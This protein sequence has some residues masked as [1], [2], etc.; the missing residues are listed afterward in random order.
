[1]AVSEAYGI[2]GMKYWFAA[3]TS[4]TGISPDMAFDA[5]TLGQLLFLRRLRSPR[6]RQGLHQNLA[7]AWAEP[8]LHHHVSLGL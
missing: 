7:V 1:M 3:E 8:L 6:R 4:S 2:V 5:G